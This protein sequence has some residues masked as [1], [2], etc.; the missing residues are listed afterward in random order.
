M[1]QFEIIIYTALALG[2]LSVENLVAL[3]VN[4]RRS[5]ETKHYEAC[6]LCQDRVGTIPLLGSSVCSGCLLTYD[7][8]LFHAATNNNEYAKKAL[9]LAEKRL[10]AFDSIGSHTFYASEHWSNDA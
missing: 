10:K 1:Q 7:T 5:I 3:L 6:A 9:R 4:R 8:L 2:A